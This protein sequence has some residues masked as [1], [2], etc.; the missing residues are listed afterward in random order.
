MDKDMMALIISSFSFVV[1][2]GALGWNIYKVFIKPR[3]K[4][5]LGL[6]HIVSPGFVEEIPRLSI[7]AS[8]FGPGI[9]RLNGVLLKEDTLWKRIRK[10]TK[11]AFVIHSYLDPLG[12]K[13]PCKMEV[14]ESKNIFLKF[15]KDCFLKEEFTHIGV[16]DTYDR[17]H[18]A[19]RKDYKRTKKSFEDWFKKNPSHTQNVS[20]INLEREEEK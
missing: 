2:G 19:S 1:A 5:R 6:Y 13:L 16:R 18:W 8:N 20:N 9:I 4:V 15:Y 7:S 14:G 12:A 10:K 11:N 3:L 17:T